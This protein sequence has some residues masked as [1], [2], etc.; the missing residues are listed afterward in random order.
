MTTLLYRFDSPDLMTVLEQQTT[1]RGPVDIRAQQHG[2]ATTLRVAVRRHSKDAVEVKVVLAL[3]LVAVDG[4]PEKF[5]LDIV[6]DGSGCLLYLEAGD[7]RG[8]GFAY[9]LGKVDFTGPGTC[10]AEV[11]RPWKYWGARKKDGTAGV[12]PPVQPFRLAIAM[13]AAC[14]GFDLCVRALHV[15]GQVRLTPP[16]FASAPDA[17]A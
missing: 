11:H 14:D 15:T 7:A 4:V 12:V 3:P 2:G 17:D 1:A 9:W 8:W 16:G 10:S 5:L 13:S 6:G